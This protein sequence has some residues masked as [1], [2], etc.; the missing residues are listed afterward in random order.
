M[1]AKCTS[2]KGWMKKKVEKMEKMRTAEIRFIFA[3]HSSTDS[4]T[5][6]YI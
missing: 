6:I 3:G 4:A 5:M 2:Q 1:K